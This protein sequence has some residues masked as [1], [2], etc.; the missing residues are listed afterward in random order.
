MVV[1]KNDW[2][3]AGQER[4]LKAAT[5]YWK[6]Y[7]RHAENWDHDHCEFCIAKFMVEDYPD[8]LHNGYATEGNDRW[9][10]EG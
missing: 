9:V 8:V 1:D 3:L 6:T 10:C 4:F 7:T 2:R 5:L